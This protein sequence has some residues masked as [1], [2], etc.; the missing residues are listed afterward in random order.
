MY[1]LQNKNRHGVYSWSADQEGELSTKP[2]VSVSVTSLAILK[3]NEK[4]SSCHSKIVLN[5]NVKDSSCHYEI[6]CN[7]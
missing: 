6:K 7:K 4:D 3:L 2:K 5:K 1:G